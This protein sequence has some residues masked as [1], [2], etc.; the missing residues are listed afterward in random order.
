MPPNKPWFPVWRPWE[1]YTLSEQQVFW[2]PV[3]GL[4]VRWEPLEEGR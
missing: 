2:E 3:I 1:K 4:P